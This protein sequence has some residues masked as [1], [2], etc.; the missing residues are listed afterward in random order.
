MSSHALRRWLCLLAA[1]VGRS[2][3][4]L[5]TMLKVVRVVISH[6]FEQASSLFEEYAASLDV[7]LRFQHFDEELSNLPAQ[8]SLPDGCLLLAFHEDLTAGC[9]ALRRLDDG[10]CEMKRLYV[11]PQFRGLKIGRLLAAR[12]IEE[13]QR[14]GYSRIRLDTLP[15]MA[16][17]QVMYKSLG[18]REIAPYRFNPVG[19][20]VFMELILESRGA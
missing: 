7:D 10:V 3:A 5:N 9:V 13:A 8:Y 12:I 16:Q 19:G 20:T 1:E 14:L 18:F 17:A 15:S 11:K 6:H 2:A 4:S